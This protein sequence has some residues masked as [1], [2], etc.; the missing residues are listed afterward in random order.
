MDVQ[1]LQSREKLVIEGLIQMMTFIR[2]IKNTISLNQHSIQVII[3]YLK[4][5]ISH[6]HPLPIEVNG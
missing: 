2:K 3:H 1:G 6:H 4:L 5:D